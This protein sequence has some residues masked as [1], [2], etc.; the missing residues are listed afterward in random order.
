MALGNPEIGGNLGQREGAQV[1][2]GVR[3]EALHRE[4]VQ[5]L[6]NLIAL[7]ENAFLEQQ[8]GFRGNGRTHVH[9]IRTLKKR[10]L[11]R[12]GQTSVIMSDSFDPAR[13]L[14]LT[15]R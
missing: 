15:G 14:R 13:T 6:G 12:T 9:S 3:R 1:L 4:K 5:L 2:P 10:F 7:F 11:A 8:R